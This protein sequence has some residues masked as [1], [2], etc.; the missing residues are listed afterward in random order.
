VR[1]VVGESERACG[2]LCLCVGG[3]NFVLSSHPKIA[4]PKK[5]R[6]NMGLIP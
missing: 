4:K 3:R 5:E 1:V 2:V 6:R